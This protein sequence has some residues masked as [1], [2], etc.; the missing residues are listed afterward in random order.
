[1]KRVIVVGD[2]QG[3]AKEARQLL[4]KLN[5]TAND[6]VVFAGDLVDRGPDNDE[7]VELAME[8]ESKQGL[9]AAIL[10]NHEEKHLHY[11]RKEKRGQNPNVQVPAHVATRLQLKEHHYEY[12]ER[13]PLYLRLPEHNTAVVHAGCFPGR[14]IEEQEEHTL[15]HVQMIRPY[16]QHGNPT[17]SA[18]SYWPSRAPSTERNPDSQPLDGWKFW[19]NFWD[20]P[21]RIVFGHSVLDKPLLTDKVCGVDGGCCFGMELRA[22]VIPDWQIVTVPSQTN[23][24]HSSRN[25][26]TGEGV[27]LYNV[28]EDVN[29]FS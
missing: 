2:L 17:N 16:D 14:S 3:C 12:I 26:A 22:V 28:H 23:Y 6:H 5:A 11:R 1:M 13:L 29:T 7:C 21:E 15:L 20:G 4:N 9:P 27:K 25:M 10:G 24:K 19:T 18:K 8:W